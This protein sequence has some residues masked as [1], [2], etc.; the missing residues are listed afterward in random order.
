M[1]V[2]ALLRI[3]RVK[4]RQ[5]DDLLAVDIGGKERQRRRLAQHRPHRQLVGR[6]GVEVAVLLQHALRLGER[7]DDE[8]AQEIRADRV[9][10][11]LE[12]A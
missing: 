4:Q 9:E 1:S 11:E 10:T 7:V 3:A 8:A 5:D 2:L 12:A 6:L